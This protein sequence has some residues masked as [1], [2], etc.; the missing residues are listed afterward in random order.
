MY[1]LNQHTLNLG[2]PANLAHP[3]LRG[4]V[5]WWQSLR[6]PYF[7]GPKLIDLIGASKGS[8]ANDGTLTSGPTWK[9]AEGRQGG[10]GSLSF[11]GSTNEVNVTA[12]AGGPTATTTASFVAWCRFGSIANYRPIIETRASAQFVG[13]LLSGDG[14]AGNPLTVV[15]NNTG[16]EYNGNSGLTVNVGEW[17]FCAGAMRGTSFDLY[18]GTL[19]GGFAKGTITGISANNRDLSG[20]WYFSIDSAAG[21]KF[22]GLKDGVMIFDRDLTDGEFASIYAD[23]LRGNPQTLNYLPARTWFL[24]TAAPATVAWGWGAETRTVGDTHPVPTPY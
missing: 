13:L 14:V 7:G 3:L 15:W 22:D 12:L 20:A 18:R 8:R 23:S 1:G 16:N 21:S 4:C 10:F 24:G 17:T 11:D 6:G 19:G 9:G 2:R 5:A